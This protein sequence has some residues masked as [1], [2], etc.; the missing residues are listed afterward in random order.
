MTTFTQKLN[1]QIQLPNYRPAYA[2]LILWILGMISLPILKWIYGE[3]AIVWGVNTTTLLQAGAVVTILA[4]HWGIKRAAQVALTVI[5]FTW[6]VEAIGTATGFPFGHYH[7]TDM[8]QPQLA[9][10]P[11]LIAIAWLMMIPSSWAVATILVGDKSFILH[12]IVAGLAMTAWDFYLDPQMVA[13]DLWR[14]DNVSGFSYFGIP[15]INFV[16]WWATA[17]LI[18]WIVRPKNLPL[19]PLL[20][21]YLIVWLMQVV[22]EAVFWEL[23]GP[24]IAGF[25]A[26]GIFAIP[27]IYQYQRHHD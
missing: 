9:N 14:W 6:G 25:I 4:T 7:Y 2:M 19:M 26:M 27:A 24:A 1:Q 22:G 16:G 3:A 11:L 17:T 18:T 10:V 8:L 23:V 21:I 13:W 15:W 5:V 12:G 20:M